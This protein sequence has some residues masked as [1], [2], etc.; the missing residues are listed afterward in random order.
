ML[1]FGLKSKSNPKLTA[2]TGLRQKF[3]GLRPKLISAIQS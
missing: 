1:K 3:D 2:Q